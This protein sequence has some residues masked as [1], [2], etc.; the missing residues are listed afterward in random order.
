VVRGVYLLKLGGS[1]GGFRLGS[2]LARWPAGYAV[3]EEAVARV[4]RELMEGPQERLSLPP[5][6]LGELRRP[7]IGE[8]EGLIDAFCVRESEDTSLIV[9]RGLFP[10]RWWP[11][12]AWAVFGAF[13]SSYG[14]ADPVSDRELA[15]SW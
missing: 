14:R 15:E 3:L 2:S 13:R 9:V 11:W 12:G 5:E 7:R 8:R 1:L 10:F 4:L 6:F